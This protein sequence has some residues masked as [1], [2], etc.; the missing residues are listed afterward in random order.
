MNPGNGHLYT[1][2]DYGGVFVSKNHG[3]TWSRIDQGLPSAPVYQM[4]YYAPKHVLIVATHGRGVWQVV[5][6]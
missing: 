1:A 3:R 4:Q 2:A 6:P 5:A